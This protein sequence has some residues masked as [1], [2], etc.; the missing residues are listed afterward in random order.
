MVPGP[1]RWLALL[2]FPAVV[3]AAPQISL[4]QQSAAAGTTALLPV[5]LA[6]SGASLSGIQFDLQFDS[7]VLTVSGAIGSGA[8]NASKNLYFGNLGGGRMRF[9]VVGMNQN[10]LPDGPV[11]NFSIAVGPNAS[12]TY[13]LTLSN[14]YAVDPAGSAVTLTAS[15]GA[16]AVPATGVTGTPLT[17]AGVVNSATW[18]SGPVAPGEIVSLAGPGIAAPT[19][20]SPPCPCTVWSATAQPGTPTDPDANP[21]EVGLKFRSD[22]PGYV[23]AV[24]FYKGP[25]NTG[26]HVGHLWTSAGTLLATAAFNSETPSGWQQAAFPSPVPVQANT[27][28]VISYYAPAGHYAS[29]SGYFSSAT[30]HP[31]L[32]ALADGTD[33]PNGVYVYGA[34]AFP[35]QSFKSAN[36]WVDVVFSATLNSP[37][38]AADLVILFNGEQAPILFASAN[39]VNTVVPADLPTSGNALIQVQTGGQTQAQTTVPLAAAAPGVFTMDG[40]GTGQGA[41]L[42]QD[43]SVNSSSNPAPRGTVVSVFGTGAGLFNSTGPMPSTVLPV[44]VQIGNQPAEVLYAGPAPGLVSGALQVNCRIPADTSPS[45]SVSISVHVGD[46]NS[47]AGVTLAVN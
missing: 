15:N 25:A 36:Y 10:A 1:S 23:T 32:H 41:I 33:G 20:A 43:T 29:D 34:G 21:V 3:A 22:Q 27:T 18:H 45:A 7:T 47:Q 4:P 11:V 38:A 9:L 17:A 46:F 16:V 12:G 13:P 35:T 31:P 8:Q 2:A 30:D 39:Q 42:N 28:Y 19:S 24:R 5:S 44:T 6:A 40:S 26:T 37:P 14:V